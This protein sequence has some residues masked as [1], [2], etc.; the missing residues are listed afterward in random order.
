MSPKP[1]GILLLD[2]DEPCS[3][4][5]TD[6]GER[7]P[8][9]V[10]NFMNHTMGVSLPRSLE[11]KIHQ[12]VP[13]GACNDIVVAS[14][15]TQSYPSVAFDNEK[16]D[17]PFNWQRLTTRIINNYIYMDCFPG[18]HYVEH[19]AEMIATY[20]VICESRGDRLTSPLLVSFLA[21]SQSD[22]QRT[23]RAMNIRGFPPGVDTVVLGHI[24]QLKRLISSVDWAN[25]GC[26]TGVVR[27][28]D[29]RTVAF[30]GCRFPFWG[31]IGGELVSFFMPNCRIPEV[32]YLASLESV[33]RGVRPN[34]RLATGGRSLLNGN[35]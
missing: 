29:H 27:Q 7:Y 32:L 19:Y 2:F 23:F 6:F 18:Y 25:S 3:L 1:N 28:L 35:L 12:A 4:A 10:A 31:D 33:K 34:T 30:I 5:Q 8:R 22:I 15:Y 26:F 14:R 24:D 17:K 13:Q 21:P 16:R 20:L 9:C 11:S